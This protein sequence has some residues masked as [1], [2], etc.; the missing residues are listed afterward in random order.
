MTGPKEQKM[1]PS[2]FS[3]SLT[4]LEIFALVLDVDVDTVGTHS[5]SWDSASWD[6]K[7]SSMIAR[8]STG[9]PQNSVSVSHGG[10]AA[11]PCVKFDLVM[12]GR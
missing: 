11:G 9:K 6:K 3:P 12:K 8:G 10:F 1:Y 5:A 2:E 4:T 7:S